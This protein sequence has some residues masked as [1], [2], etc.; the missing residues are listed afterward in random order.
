MEWLYHTLSP[1]WQAGLF[2][3]WLQVPIYKYCSSLCLCY[4]SNSPLVLTNPDQRAGKISSS[5]LLKDSRI[6]GIFTIY[7]K[8]A[9]S[10]GGSDGKESACRV[11]DLD[12][13][14]GSGRSPGGGHGNPLQYS[15]LENLQGQRSQWAAVQGVAKSQTWL[16]G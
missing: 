10:N 9:C 3:L 16:S 4:V 13:V 15:C 7:P 14:P 1:V 11:G 6:V 2:I 8:L 12:S 5:S